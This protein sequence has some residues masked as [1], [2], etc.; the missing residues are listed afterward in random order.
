ML[1]GPDRQKRGAD[2]AF[3]NSKSSDYLQREAFDAYQQP[4]E[5][6][7]PENANGV[8]DLSQRMMAHMLGLDVPGIEPSTSFYPGY[9]WWPRTTDRHDSQHSL[10]PGASSSN[11]G[12]NNGMGGVLPQHNPGLGY[13]G[14]PVEDWL[15]G[16]ADP[17]SGY[18]YDFSPLNHYG[19]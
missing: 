5:K 8:Q 11:G 16:N 1:Q 15:Q 2:D 10:S 9:E 14:Q 7:V 3:G 19:N 6:D 12:L 4:V 13:D 17:N 18:N